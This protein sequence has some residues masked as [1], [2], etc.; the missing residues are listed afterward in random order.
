VIGR[1]VLPIDVQRLAIMRVSLGSTP[2]LGFDI[3]FQE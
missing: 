2:L 3:R 1:E